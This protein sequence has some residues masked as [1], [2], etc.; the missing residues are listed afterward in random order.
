MTPAS[1]RAR[2]AASDGSD[3]REI[4]SKAF[5]LLVPEPD[6]ARE[7][8]AQRIWRTA[9]ARWDSFCERFYKATEDAE[10]YIDGAFIIAEAV[11]RG[12]GLSI[13][14]NRSMPNGAFDAIVHP[15]ASFQGYGANYDPI[16]RGCHPSCRALAIID[17]VCAAV[18]RK[19]ET[20][21]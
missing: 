10:A 16:G 12:A 17:A 19:D 9:D 11:L 1:I 21:G 4:I 15:H 3:E 20:N 7:R 6:G 5:V 2:I 8:L 14:D 18:E 13:H